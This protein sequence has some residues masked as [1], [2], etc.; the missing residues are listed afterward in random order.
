MSLQEVRQSDT[1]TNGDRM[2]QHSLELSWW[3]V[4]TWCIWYWTIHAVQQR[5]GQL[6][7]WAT[8]KGSQEE[9][10]NHEGD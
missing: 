2:F 5:W 8:W 6:R 1:G 3:K 4:S 10:A 9:E 7:N